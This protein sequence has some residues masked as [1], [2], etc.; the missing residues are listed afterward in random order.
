MPRSNSVLGLFRRLV[1]LRW[2]KLSLNAKLAVGAAA[3]LAIGAIVS[4]ALTCP[5]SGGCCMREQA[6]L[7][8]EPAALPAGHPVVTEEAEPSSG[9]RYSGQH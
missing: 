5:A 9:C 8:P 2:K 6:E 4:G 1:V 3:L 7:S